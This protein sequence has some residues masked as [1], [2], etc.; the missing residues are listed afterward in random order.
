ME[1]QPS[2]TPVRCSMLFWPALEAST[3]RTPSGTWPANTM[4]SF[5]CFVRGGEVSIARNQRLNF[6]EVRAVGFQLIHD[7]ASV[8]GVFHGRGTWKGGN[9]TIEHGACDEHARPE[10]I[11]GC[12]ARA[13]FFQRL[14][15]ASH[16][17]HAS[18]SVRD[19]EQ[20]DYLFVFREPSAENFMHVHIPQAGDQILAARVDDTGVFRNGDAGARPEFSDALGFDDYGHVRLRE[21]AGGIN[22]RGVHEG[23]SL[24]GRSRCDQRCRDDCDSEQQ[25]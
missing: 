22:Y 14:Q 15:I 6:D 24:I 18:D 12:D 3:A 2:N 1:E 10:K 4:S 13:P 11:T 9:G 21:R 8:R 16:I 19:K 17:A 7:S 23:E 25:N 5:F 20:G